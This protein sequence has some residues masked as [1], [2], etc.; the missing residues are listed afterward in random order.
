MRFWKYQGIGNDFVLLEDDGSAPKEEAFVRRVCDRR[1]GIG[2][3]GILYVSKAENVDA[4]MMI[5]N[6]DG[7]EAEMCGNGIRCV[8][9]HLYDTGAVPK[10]EMTVDTLAGLMRISLSVEGGKA[11]TVTVNMGAPILDCERIPMRCGGKFI[12]GIIEVDGRK[13]RGTAVSMGNPHLIT[14]ERLSKEEKDVLGPKLEAHPAFPKRTNVEFVTVEGL[15]LN[16]RVFERG[17]GWTLACGT[18][19]CATVVAAALNGLVPFNEDIEVALPGGV[20][21]IS[22]DDLLSA[23]MMTGPAE[24]VFEGTI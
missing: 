16:V 10:E 22:V 18:G 6:A 8:A 24:L 9:K 4:R 13:L 23:V 20:L 3:D 21:S 11:R 7:S 1:F 12:D 19:A 15:R 14:F 2:A 17:V 5:L